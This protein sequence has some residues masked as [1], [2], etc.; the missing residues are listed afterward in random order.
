MQSISR[1]IHEKSSF[2]NAYYLIVLE[3]RRTADHADVLVKR[4][5]NALKEN[6]YKCLFDAEEK[7]FWKSLKRL[8]I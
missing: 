4:Q 3:R 8:N 7:K 1:S 2:E 6:F 5:K